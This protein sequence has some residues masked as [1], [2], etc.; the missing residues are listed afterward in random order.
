MQPAAAQ[1]FVARRL[2]IPVAEHDGVPAHQHLTHLARWQWRIVPVADAQAYAGKGNPHRAQARGIARMG[3]VAVQVLGHRG[4]GHRRL[5]LAIDLRKLVAKALHRALGIL[6]IHRPAA[7]DDGLDIVAVGVTAC[8]DQALD[9]GRRG[10]HGQAAQ[11]FL[12]A[13]QGKDFVRVETAGLWH[14]VERGAGDVRQYVQPGA[15]RHRRGVQNRVRGG[16]LVDVGKII[17]CH[18][19][20][21]VVRQHH[22]LG[23]AGG[24]AGI[25]QPGEGVI[26]NFVD[27]GGRRGEQARVVRSG[28]IYYARQC[29][30]APGQ[31]GDIVFAIGGD[32]A[33]PGAA[34][35]DDVIELKRVQL[36][37]DRHRDQSGLPAGEQGLDIL[38]AVGHHQRNAVTGSKAA[39]EQSAGEARHAQGQFAIACGDAGPQR[40]R[41]ALREDARGA[42]QQGGKIDG[43][44]AA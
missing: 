22:A 5:A 13:Q 23:P 2:V 12:C 43:R 24:A 4:D 29:A 34:V 21:V 30:A 38:R 36:G 11:A 33:Q 26:G 31:R 16:D 6:D 40:Q 3:D 39:L 8:V 1:G 44:H 25:E 15:M 42:Q 9:H 18:R 37:V 28:H 10:E 27:K 20:Q 41:R 17:E 35:G 32:K 7:V 19:H 14:G